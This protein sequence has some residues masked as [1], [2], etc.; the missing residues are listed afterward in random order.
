M[1]SKN[2]IKRVNEI[3]NILEEKEY[4]FNLCGNWIEKLNSSYSENF[5]EKPKLI[6]IP[7]VSGLSDRFVGIATIFLLSLIT[8][9]LFLLGNIPELIPLESVYSLRFPQMTHYITD[10]KMIPFMRE[11]KINRQAT[12]IEYDSY[13]NNNNNNNPLIINSIGDGEF[14][15]LDS[16]ISR[17]ENLNISNIYVVSN[18]GRS[19][20]MFDHP[21][22]K[23]KLSKLG[24]KKSTAF[25]CALRYIF[26]PRPEIFLPILPTLETLVKPNVIKIAIHIRTHDGVL[27]YG[28]KINFNN[29]ASYF[30]C[31]KQIEEFSNS[32]KKEEKK[33]VVWLLFTDSIELRKK[34]LKRYGNKLQTTIDVPIEHSAKEMICPGQTCVS[35]EGFQIAAAE[36]WSLGLADYHIIGIQGGYGKT[37][38]MRAG[39][40]NSTYLIYPDQTLEQTKCSRKKYARV[41][42]IKIA[43][44][45]V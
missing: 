11:N 16:T 35:N 40:L 4:S 38:L 10:S 22:L 33:E 31:A 24:L 44:A 17:M 25:G 14:L 20:A 13:N 26:K 9:R 15:L 6:S 28:N 1:N 8:N 39:R 18:R 12:I 29:Y 37:A 2:K 43:Y 34:A 30:T 21:Y 23:Y 32:K 41:S 5:T 42:E 27:V 19:I 36:W 7:H 45:G 3:M